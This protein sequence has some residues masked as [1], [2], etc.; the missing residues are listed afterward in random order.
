[1]CGAVLAV[2]I[3]GCGLS[4]YES[5]MRT[6]QERVSRFTEE[7]SSLG[8]PVAVP[9]RLVVI[10]PPAPD[11]KAAAASKDQKTSPGTSKDSKSGKDQK[12]GAK[13]QK[14]SAPSTERRKVVSYSFFLRLPRGIR[15]TPDNDAKYDGAY[16]Y[17]KDGQTTGV[18][19][20]YLSFGSEP[21][22]VFA[23]KVVRA[24]PRN[25]D[26]V[27][28]RTVDIPVPER[29]EPLHFD[30]RDFNDASTSWS[31]YAH[32]EGT[33]T[34]AITYRM[35]PAQKSAADPVINLSLSTLAIGA[36]ADQV[37][38]SIAQRQSARK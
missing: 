18:I 20:V 8:E 21:Q 31:V 26:P 23:D 35:L 14:S 13:E 32:T 29:A 1:L 5:R 16:R 9:T 24:M 36:E 34:V 33:S 38:Q 4:D 12:S 7:S 10:N 6:V 3:A 17:P 28:V 25:S 2:L 11:P 15:P 37:L 27:A 30:V 22:G 19:E